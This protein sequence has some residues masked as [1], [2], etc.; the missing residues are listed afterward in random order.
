M[1]LAKHFTKK[2]HLVD[3]ALESFLPKAS[4]KPTTLHHAM[5]YSVFA[6]GKR[7]R[8]L[9]CL[10][11]CEA[12]GGNATHALPAAAAIECLHTYSL[13][14]DDLP[15]M[16]D[17]DFRRGRPTAHKTF[18]EGIA[19]LAG[20][21][22]LTL[23]FEILSQSR[24]TPRYPLATLLFELS[25][26][27]GSCKLIAGQVADLEGEGRQS[28]HSELRFIHKCKTAAMI[29]VSLRLG[30]MAANAPAAK[31]S[32]L[33]TFGENLGLAFQ[34]I[35][36]ILDVTQTSKQLGKSVGKDVTAKKM[37]YPALIGLEASK[38]EAERLTNN[39]LHALRPLR[40][41]ENPLC[42]LAHYLLSR[43]C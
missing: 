13:I 19:T 35:D 33:T 38:R 14:H 34:I 8:P 10:T 22:L 9:L 21:A 7:I 37:T 12:C 27:A 15:C 3:K 41:S 20:D 23:A 32:A 18:G 17:D 11:A 25:H 39:A 26:G 31:L 16:D 5:R 4:M 2:I 43:Q 24:T 40:T 36:D 42:D 28:T 29:I 30:A 6:G 1:E